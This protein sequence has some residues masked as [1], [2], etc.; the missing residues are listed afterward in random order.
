MQLTELSPSC[1]D[2]STP[3]GWSSMSLGAA[4]IHPTSSSALILTFYYRDCFNG[5][6]PL[7]P[8]HFIPQLSPR[9]LTD[10]PVST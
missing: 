10:R 6:N 8:K 5:Q 2:F 1:S 3:C 7:F 4:V 9:T